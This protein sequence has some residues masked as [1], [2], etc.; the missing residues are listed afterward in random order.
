MRA[1]EPTSVEHSIF[2]LLLNPPSG[3]VFQ[4]SRSY[5]LIIGN[6]AH[7]F[8]LHTLHLD[9]T[10]WG[11]IPILLTVKL[12]QGK[13]TTVVYK[14]K[15]TRRGEVERGLSVIEQAPLGGSKAP[16]SPLGFRLM[17]V[18]PRRIACIV[19]SMFRARHSGVSNPSLFPSFRGFRGYKAT[20]VVGLLTLGSV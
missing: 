8:P 2:R 4:C 20:F 5:T 9:L 14:R 11:K 3:H 13:L 7:F 6:V 18:V 1:S 15:R 19:L 16:P 10:C 12:S 17:P